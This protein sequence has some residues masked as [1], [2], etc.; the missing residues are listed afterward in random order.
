MLSLVHQMISKHIPVP[1]YTP[2]SHHISESLGKTSL[3][4]DLAATGTLKV[5]RY[6]WIFYEVVLLVL[7]FQFILELFCYNV[8][9]FMCML[10][11]SVDNS[12]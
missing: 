4:E 5:F 7:E 9:R 12:M 6:S 8:V 3:D 1:G 11:N 2:A 10:A